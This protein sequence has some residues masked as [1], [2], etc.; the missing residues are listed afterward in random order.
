MTISTDQ[1]NYNG[2]DTYGREKKGLFRQRTTPVGSFPA[3]FWGL[4]DMHSQVWE[5]CL[6]WYDGCF[7]QTRRAVRNNPVNRR[8]AS[9]RVCRGA[10]W[11]PGGEYCRSASRSSAQPITQNPYCGFRLTAVA[12]LQP[13]KA[14]EE[15]E[16]QERSLY[17]GDSELTF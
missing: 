5:W 11:V 16:Q 6:D 10:G 9:F 8:A 4:F 14:S 17:N 12:S 15:A 3:N 13:S 2:E 1:A 7:Y